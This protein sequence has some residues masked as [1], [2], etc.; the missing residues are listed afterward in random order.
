MSER[1]S[2]MAKVLVAYTTKFGSTAEVAEVIGEELKA[3]GAAAD[4]RLLS[5]VGDVGAYDAVLVGG[6]MIIGWQRAAVRFL[7]K[8]Q[9]TLSKKPVALFMTA[10]ALTKTAQDRIGD[11]AVF[12]DPAAAK[13]PKNPDRPS[14]HE[15][16]STPSRYLGA[17]L[18]KVP[19]VKP[20]AA[21]LFGG[22]LDYSRLSLL[23]LLFVK[24]AVRAKEEDLRNWEA[25]RS[26]ARGL[27][28]L[29]NAAK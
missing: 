17:V 8:N 6:P 26:W 2:D 14:I 29:L 21:G 22:K 23:Q 24:V 9:E 11:T 20:V 25:I 12:Q 7:K 5:D 13:V 15:W 10:M 18:K 16:F 1:Q 19:V 4:V 28:P 27:V 3:G